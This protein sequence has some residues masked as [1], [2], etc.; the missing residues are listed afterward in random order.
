MMMRAAIAVLVALGCAASSAAS[1]TKAPLKE[2]TAAAVNLE[3]KRRVSLVNFEIVMPAKGRKPETI[4]GKL[5]K[6]LSAGESVNVPLLGAKGCIF[7]VRWKFEDAND[8]APVDLCNEAHI[9][10]MD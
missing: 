5:E 9:V 10:L 3:N 8:A 1:K 4:V 2:K 6:A 7:Q